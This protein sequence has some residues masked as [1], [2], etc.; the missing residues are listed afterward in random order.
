MK[1]SDAQGIKGNL[2]L[3]FSF[4]WRQVKDVLLQLNKRNFQNLLTFDYAYAI[5]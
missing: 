3:P 5:I 1:H 2:T 4:A